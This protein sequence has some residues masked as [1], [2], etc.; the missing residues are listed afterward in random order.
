MNKLLIFLSFIFILSSCTPD[1]Q[2]KFAQAQPKSLKPSKAFKNAKQGSYLNVK[3]K[4]ERLEI[5]KNLILKTVTYQFTVDRNT[6]VIN[7]RAN[8][9]RNNDSSLLSYF[10]QLGGDASIEGDIITYTSN[11]IDTVFI[12]GEKEVLKYY[13]H[14]Y[15]LN[16]QNN[17]SLWLVRKLRFD[18]DTLL[19]GKITPNDTLLHFDYTKVD[20]SHIDEKNKTYVLDPSKRE[21]KKL[22][23]SEVFE[24]TKKYIKE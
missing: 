12:I 20:S 13:R 18:G 22:M 17:D 6:V 16:F 11:I 9:D 5:E 14:S 3:N 24:V 7:E 19:L 10:K 15:F 23:R 4:H 21:S 1:D 2:V 8:I